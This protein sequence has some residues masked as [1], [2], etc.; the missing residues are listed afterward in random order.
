M[1]ALFDI[2]PEWFEIRFISVP[3]DRRSLNEAVVKGL[4]ESFE[5]VGQITPILCYFDLETESPVLVAGAHRLEAAKRLGWDRIDGVM[6]HTDS[7]TEDLDYELWEID[8]NLI[9]A[10]LTDLERANHTARRAEIVKYKAESAKLAE[11]ENN[12]REKAESLIAQNEPKVAHRPSKGQVAFVEETAS[13]TG[14]SAASVKRDKRRGE[15][16]TPEVKDAI[17][18]MPA[19]DKGVELD[20]LAS[21]EPDEQAQ[22]VERVKSGASTDFREAKNF[23]KGDEPSP[24][25]LEFERLKKAWQKA[26]GEA[27]DK[28]LAWISQDYEKAAGQ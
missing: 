17:K 2:D 26:G 9:R 13:M 15:K 19:A 5:E 25:A 11:M 18:D 3:P 10:E 14:K 4:M 8:E 1:T 28:F 23:I 27:R 24:S 21:L 16:I 20:A 22:A 6:L 12:M 7:D